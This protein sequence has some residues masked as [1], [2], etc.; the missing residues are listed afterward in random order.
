[1]ASGLPNW[2]RSLPA[3]R[4]PRP[5]VNASAN[6]PK[7]WSGSIDCAKERAYST[8]SSFCRRVELRTP[9]RR[10]MR[11]VRN[12]GVGLVGACVDNA[13][14]PNR[15]VDLREVCRVV[16]RVGVENHQI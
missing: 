7:Y 8:G 14:A 16:R 1:M 12:C 2:P 4:A 9:K 10:D 3:I 6:H 11:N 13:T 15:I 5:G